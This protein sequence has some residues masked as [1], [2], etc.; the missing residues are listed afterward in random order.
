MFR[1]KN[2]CFSL[3]DN[4]TRKPGLDPSSWNKPALR[5]HRRRVHGSIAQKKVHFLKEVSRDGESARVPRPFGGANRVNPFLLAASVGSLN[6]NEEMEQNTK[7]S[8]RC[9]YSSKGYISIFDEIE[10][11]I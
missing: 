10:T 5:R 6:H 1:N 4:P 2:P 11:L 7:H 9:P 8:R 3:E